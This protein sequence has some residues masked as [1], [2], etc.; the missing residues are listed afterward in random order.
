MPKLG[1][2]FAYWLLKT[3]FYTSTKK[4]HLNTTKCML[5]AHFQELHN[6]RPTICHQA[7]Q[8][9]PVDKTVGV[10]EKSHCQCSHGLIKSHTINVILTNKVTVSVYIHVS[11]THH[12]Y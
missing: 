5:T 6:C 2:T 4:K 10:K 1:E 12:N 9:C 3:K 7:L 8:K 11:I